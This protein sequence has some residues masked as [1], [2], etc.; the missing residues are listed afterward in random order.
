MDRVKTF[1]REN[2]DRCDEVVKGLG[3]GAF[4]GGVALFTH[5][6]GVIEGIS[7]AV[8]SAD[9]W[10]RDDGVEVISVALKDGTSVILKKD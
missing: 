5:R 6:M 7:T 1:Y 2:K 3:I 8:V 4:I 10:T 9:T